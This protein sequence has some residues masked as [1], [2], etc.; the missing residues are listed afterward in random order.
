MIH[1]TAN[2][3]IHHGCRCGECR[4]ANTALCADT[5]ARLR[6]NGLPDEAD[7]RHGTANGYGNY[8]CRCSACVGAQ[9]DQMQAWRDR[10]AT[11]RQEIA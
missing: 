6:A 9:R 3:Y 11:P 2:G 1:G 10:Q 4:A 8:G 5:K 7:P